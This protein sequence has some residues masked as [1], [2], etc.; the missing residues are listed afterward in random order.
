MLVIAPQPFFTDRGTPIATRHFLEALGELGYAADVLTYPM[1]QPLEVP[2]VRLI[3]IANPLRIRS[4][5]IGFSWRKCWLDLFFFRELQRCLRE[6]DYACVC[7]IEESAFIAALVAPRHGVPVVYDMQSSLPEQMCQLFP[8]RNSPSRWVLERFE[9]WLVGHV[10][11]VMTSAGLAERVRGVNRNVRVREWRYPAI[12][13]E[14]QPRRVEEL[15]ARLGLDG[16]PIILYSGSFKQY[17]GLMNLLEAMPGLLERVP[18]AVLLLVGAEKGADDEEVR[19]LARRL[20]ASSLR[21]LERQPH[22]TMPAYLK[23]ADVVVSPRL[24][25]G[26]LPLKV[27]EYLAAGRAIVATSI[28]AHRTVLDHDRALLVEPNADALEVGI[29]SLLL[30]ERRRKELER[31][32]RRFAETHLGWMGF[33][34]G[35]REFL[36]DV[37][38]RARV[39]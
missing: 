34:H 21:I 20:P 37:G 29:A 33:V 30:D 1:G 28:P 10:D 24:Y 19:K 13:G 5:P 36:E 11:L 18:K 14:V 31:S 3:R 39:G 15:R 2:G 23:L 38:A 26:N 27:M 16:E 12:E 6:N 32:A 35:V 7:A 8:F 9:R 4:V 17:Q 22:E 25:G